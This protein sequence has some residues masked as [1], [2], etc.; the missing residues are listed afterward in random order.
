MER[1][2]VAAIEKHATGDVAA[3]ARGVA[4]MASVR[5]PGSVIFN[6]TTKRRRRR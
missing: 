6:A 3:L 2:I 1:V 4:A 5:K